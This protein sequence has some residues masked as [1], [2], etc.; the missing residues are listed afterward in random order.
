MRDG[1]RDAYAPLVWQYRFTGIE[2]PEP[3]WTYHDFGKGRI[4]AD[5]QAEQLPDE[6]GFF[7]AFDAW[8]DRF[9]AH[10]AAKGL[11][12]AGKFRAAG[13]RVPSHRWADVKLKWREFRL[14]T[15]H[16]PDRSSPARQQAAG[17]NQDATF[18]AER[19]EAARH[20]RHIGQATNGDE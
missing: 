3:L 10:V 7:D 13:Y 9:A 4:D 16:P 1:L 20:G 5:N 17:L 6:P 11:V 15:G 19:S 2:V 8:T 14:S 12:P 18:S